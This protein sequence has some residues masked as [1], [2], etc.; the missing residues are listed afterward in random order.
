MTGAVQSTGGT[1]DKFIGDSVMAFWNAPSRCEDHALRACR[2]VLECQRAAAALFASPAWAPLP[3][4]VTR[5]GLNSATVMVGHF[6]AP[7]RLGYTAL[8]DGVNLASRLEGLCKGYGV[9]TL[10][11]E[12]VVARARGEVA[13]RMVDR[14]AVKGKRAATVV[15]E[16]LGARGDVGGALLSRAAA[17][18]EALAA[19]FSRDFSG[20]LARFEALAP[21]D[22]PS[23]VLAA[24]CAAMVAHPPPDDWGGV[25]VALTK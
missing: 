16:L 17:Y 20:A 24:R 13:F 21:D 23:A 22:P 14:V 25:H 4:L 12:A 7:D 15:Y 18:E 3:P 1:V 2:A 10:A 11:S 19:Y 9:T 5:F 6:G 8:G